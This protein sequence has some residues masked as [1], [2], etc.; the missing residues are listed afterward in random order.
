MS[1]I[2]VK[3]SAGLGNQLFMF[4]NAFAL[5]KIKN[6][7]LIIDDKSGF[8]RKKET[9]LERTF[10]LNKFNISHKSFSNKSFYNN[11]FS[12]FLRKFF[13][14]FDKFKNKKKFLIE[15]KIN[16]IKTTNFKKIDLT[17]YSSNFEVLGH[18]ECEKYFLN[19]RKDLQNLLIPNINLFNNS[20]KE[21]HEK[22][23]SMLIS[24]NSISI[25]V[26]CNGYFGPAQKNYKKF[27]EIKISSQILYIKKAISYFNNIIDDPKFFIWSNNLNLVKEY[28]DNKIYTFIETSNR[29]TDFSLFQYCN[30]FIVSPS[31]FHWMGA[32]L[33]NNSKKICIRPEN[34]N[35]SNNLDFWPNDWIKI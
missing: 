33:N 35:P 28:F 16:K 4:A 22:F 15:H 30:H 12:H 2:V 26:R 9:T 18:Y 11:F 3:I 34:M 7:T 14:F 25:H 8:F 29:I 6:S 21:L 17:N 24:T 1:K 10:G 32:W 20:Q 23:K 27:D 31:T 19:Y 13:V 5:S